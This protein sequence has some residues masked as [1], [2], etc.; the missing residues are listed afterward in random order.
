[1]AYQ[2][3]KRERFEEIL[4]LVDKKGNVV[5]SI[6]VQLAP[7]DIVVKLNRK[8]NALTKALVESKGLQREELSNIEL[9]KSFEKLGRA[10]IDLFEAVFGKED[11]DTIVQFYEYRYIEMV[12]E[13]MPFIKQ[14]VI[15]RCVEISKLNQK[16][17]LNKYTRNKRSFLWR[18]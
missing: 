1:M 11:A 18:R 8:Y 16:L 9:E 7:D 14:C 10:V 5:H 6:L 3:R 12:Q 15:P 17:T 13:V 4:E 2:A